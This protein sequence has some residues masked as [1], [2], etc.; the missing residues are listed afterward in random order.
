VLLFRSCLRGALFSPGRSSDFLLEKDMSV[1]S[2][3]SADVGGWTIGQWCDRWQICRSMFYKL[4]R[5]GRGPRVIK[6]GT[7]SRITRDADA[8]WQRGHTE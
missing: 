8:E 5:Q 2:N 6:I 1:E 4:Q 7:S 3:I